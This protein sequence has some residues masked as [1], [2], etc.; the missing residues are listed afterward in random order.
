MAKTPLPPSATI[1]DVVQ[2]LDDP[3]EYVRGVLENLLACR[4][5]TEGPVQ[6]R[7]G[8]KGRGKWPLMRR[9]GREAEGGGLLNRIWS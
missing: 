2:G 7:I 8:I 3:E 5:E 9:R 4:R 6:V 1:V